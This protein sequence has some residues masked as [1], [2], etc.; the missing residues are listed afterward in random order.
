MELHPFDI[1][2]LV[3]QAHDLVDRAIGMGGPGGD[4]QAVGQGFALDHQGM[5]AGYGQRVVEGGEHA[6][7][8][9]VDRAGLAV[10]HLA[11]THHVTAKGLADGL[12]AQAH[13]QDWQL[14]GKM[15]DGL[16]GHARLARCAR[17]RGYDDA[18]RV[19]GFD[20]GDG[21]FVIANDL[22]LGTQLAKVLNDVV[23]E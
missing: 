10:H 6:Q 16:D 18:L 13:T 5:V 1:Q 19:E 12:V 7:V 4:F 20:L 23:S 21:H 2:G 3:A 11:R 14:A 9:V 15:Q 8:A 22:D 17:A